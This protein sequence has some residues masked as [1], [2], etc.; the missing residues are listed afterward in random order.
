MP[1]RACFVFID[2]PSADNVARGHI[3]TV[4]ADGWPVAATPALASALALAWELNQFEAAEFAAAFVAANKV[5]PGLGPRLVGFGLWAHLAPKD[6]RF[7]YM[8][9]QFASLHVGV[10]CYEIAWDPE[11][12]NWSHAHQWDWPLKDIGKWNPLA[13]RG[14]R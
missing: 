9:Q 11:M 4:P 5:G 2:K 3:V 14:N 1:T 8:V 13:A 6:T 10:R 7:L 12:G